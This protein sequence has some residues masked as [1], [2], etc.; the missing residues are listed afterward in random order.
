MSE[1]IY[2]AAIFDMDGTIL[3]TLLDLADSTNYALNKLN[4]KQRT[5][6]EI[7]NF[8]GNGIYKLIERAVGDHQE[9]IEECFE[10]FKAHY[11]SNSTNKTTPYKNSLETLLYLKEK[12]VKLAVLSNKIDS[13]VKKLSDI[14]FKGIFDISIGESE[15]FPKKPN[16]ASTNYIIEQFG[17]RKNEVLFIGDSEVDIQT[18]N[19][20]KIDCISASWGYKTKD[21]LIKN[22]AKVIIDNFEQLKNYF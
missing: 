8:V 20:A 21:F 19:Y 13:E 9:K 1:K 16:P 14:Y 11:K 17:L 6:E 18:A 4:L 5:L 10:I 3:Y 15:N 2:K 12:G 22:N 7:R